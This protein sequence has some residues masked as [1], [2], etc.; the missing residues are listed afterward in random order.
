M[1][2]IYLFAAMATML[3]ACSENDL[4]K[5]EAAVQQNAEPGAV[6]FESYVNRPTTRS[7][8]TGTMT[9]NTDDSRKLV[10]T[11]F[12][13]FGFYTDDNEYDGQYLPNFMYNEKIFLKTGS[14]NY[15]T[16]EPVKY[17]PN[18][19][20]NSAIADDADK[21]SFF[22]YAPYVKVT[23][24]TGKAENQTYGITQLS[25]N[26][27]T[28][29]PYVKYLASF[30]WT[31]NVDLL[32]GVCDEP[33]W[34][35]VAGENQQ[36]NNGAKGLPW[37]NVQRPKTAGTQAAQTDNRVKF[38]F[39][40]ALSQLNV[41]VDYDADQEIHSLIDNS[42]ASSTRVYVRSV[43]FTGFSMKGSLNLNN[44]EP[45]TP[46]WMAYDAI[47]DLESGE[48]TTIYD[49]RKDGK[50]GSSSAIASNEKNAFLNP[51]IIQTTNWNSDNKGV[52]NRP[53]NLFYFPGAD[54]VAAD[55]IANTPTKSVTLTAEEGI[56]LGWSSGSGIVY[57]NTSTGGNP[58]NSG[59]GAKMLGWPVMVIPNGD[60]VT[61]TIVY[62]VE[63]VDDKLPTTVSDN[64]TKGSSI[65]NN[66]TKT[67]TFS[68]NATRNYMEAGKKYTIQLHLGLNSVKFEAAVDEWG[69]NVVEGK[70]WFPANTP[71]YQA[72]GVYDY[73]VAATA[74]E[75]GGFTINGFSPNEALI[76]NKVTTPSLTIT[77]EPT[78]ADET[79]SAEIT[80]IES[81]TKN[82]SVL[83]KTIANAVTF[84]GADSG[85][86]L[87]L[88]I[89]QK[90]DELSG[91]TL[92]IPKDGSTGTFT[93]KNA[94]SAAVKDAVWVGSKRNVTI[95]SAK[96]NGYTMTEVDTTPSGALQFKCASGNGTTNEGTITLGTNAIEGEV[97]EFTIK[98]GDAGEVT[99]TCTVS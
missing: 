94:T 62:D 86:E 75:T 66:I 48:E 99:I 69:A 10:D 11:G 38:N 65:E 93:L 47:S 31:K 5:E 45:N 4:G 50:E 3:A 87:V 15:W 35:I 36:I 18:E 83:N 73:T 37:L 51:A 19:Y 32:W 97:F 29:D 20:G 40:H 23:P 59:A 95:V 85:K 16:Y 72:P 70:E 27:L 28:G 43:T 1:K 63:T 67:I 12:G 13:V 25:R 81:L 46:L 68:T 77:T 8:A 6:T 64:S 21:V 14:P 80:K 71:T 42:L 78:V 33:S 76:V 57:Q 39:K 79:G 49:G 41:Q 74:V 58:P 90:A 2:K 91:S 7:G 24:N 88:N 44:I 96:R 61:V 92:A 30:D 26:S 34:A 9:Y 84:T 52:Q 82:A 17:W 54:K 60:E 53:Q 22:A 89:V 98:A 55:M 56:G